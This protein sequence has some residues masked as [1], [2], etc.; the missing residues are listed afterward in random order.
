[1]RHL[2]HGVD[3]DTTNIEEDYSDQEGPNHWTPSR[4]KQIVAL[5]QQALDEA[6][7]RWADYIF[8]S[9]FYIY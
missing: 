4:F 2:Y 8:V 5:R 9:G 1:M 6:R 7:R 3:I